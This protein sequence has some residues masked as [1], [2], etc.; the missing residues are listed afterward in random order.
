MAARGVCT[1]HNKPGI[2]EEKTLE[3]KITKGISYSISLA[4]LCLCLN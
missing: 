2:I 3:I 4:L 1:G